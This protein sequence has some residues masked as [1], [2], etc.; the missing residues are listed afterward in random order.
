MKRSAKILCA[1][2]IIIMLASCVAMAVSAGSAY[3]TYTYSIGGYALY[4]PDAYVADANIITSDKMGLEVPLSQNVSDLIT[5][6]KDNIYIA[7]TGNNRIVCLDRYY[8]EKFIIS[9]FVNDKGVADKLSAPQGLFVTEDRIWVCD[10]GKQRIV[11][12][13][14]NGEFIKIIE[15]P[16]SNLF[17]DN[18]LY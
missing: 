13:D 7:D 17:G 1:L 9:S 18:A 11:V 3:Q 16:K 12:F 10:T 15:A 8:V 4:S 2:F 6:D 5:D 14:R